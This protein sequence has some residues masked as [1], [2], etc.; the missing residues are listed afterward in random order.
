MKAMLFFALIGTA[1]LSNIT[2]S[3]AREYPWCAFYGP[4][5]HNCGFT[6]FEQCLATISGI[7]GHCAQN[8]LY[9][10]D[11]QQPRYRRAYPY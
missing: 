9:Q 7:G 6:T 11:P 10:G 8:P 2:P 3:A 4:S 1:M 5:T